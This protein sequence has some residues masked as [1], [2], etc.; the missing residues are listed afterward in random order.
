M[1]DKILSSSSITIICGMKSKNKIIHNYSIKLKIILDGSHHFEGTFRRAIWPF[2][3]IGQIYGVMP[4]IGVSSRSL[5]D[6]HFK[7]KSS[8]TI[9]AVIV[10]IIL[11]SYSLFLLW[12]SFIDIAYFNISMGLP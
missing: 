10:A 8:R 9:Y 1:K 2:L 4:V 7:W 11:S 6:L 5:S 3:F 12:R